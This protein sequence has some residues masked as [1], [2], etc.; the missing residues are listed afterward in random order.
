MAKNGMHAHR[1]KK[2]S[3]YFVYLLLERLVGLVC[4][5]LLGDVYNQ[6]THDLARVYRGISC[7]LHPRVFFTFVINGL[8]GWHPN[9]PRPAA[10]RDKPTRTGARPVAGTGYNISCWI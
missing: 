8:A 3:K 6:I 10:R 7:D 2:T 4:R 5:L 1:E 9:P